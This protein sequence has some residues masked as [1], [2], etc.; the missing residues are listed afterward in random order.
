[1]AYINLYKFIVE[2]GY[3]DLIGCKYNQ[4][5]FCECEEYMHLKDILSKVPKLIQN[6]NKNLQYECLYAKPKL[7]ECICGY[8]LQVQKENNEAYGSNCT[9]Y[10]LS[11]P[12]C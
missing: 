12:Y 2:E 5:N 1:M 11:C 6:K 9:E 3:C 4:N 8:K 10:I 7:N